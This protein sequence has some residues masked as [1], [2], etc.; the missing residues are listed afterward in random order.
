MYVGFL[1]GFLQLFPKELSAI[2]AFGKFMLVKYV[3]TKA[4]LS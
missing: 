3:I 1:E 4:T 2:V